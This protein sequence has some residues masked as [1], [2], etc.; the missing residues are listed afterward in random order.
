VAA[1]CLFAWLLRLSAL[2]KL[3][4]D[5]ILVGVKAGAGLTISMTSCRNL[6]G[7]PS[8]GHNFFE[9]AV[10]FV[11][12]LGQMHL[13]VLVVGVV[14]IVLLVLGDRVMPGKPTALAVVGLWIIAASVLDLPALGVPTTGEIPAGLPTLSAPALRLR[15]VEGII[16]LAGGCLLLAYIE[17]V[18]AARSFAGLEPARS[19]L[20]SAP[21]IS[22]L[23]SDRATPWR[24]DSRNR[25]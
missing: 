24:A 3:I 22:R 14:A 10:L 7:V 15:D 16:P 23:R 25:Q 19:S 12:Q 18:A 20:A 17:G 6:F 8:G 13:L 9:R 5:S 21:Q 2:V 11:G 1:L 4:S